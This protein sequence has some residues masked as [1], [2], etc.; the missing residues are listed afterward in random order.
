[1]K[2]QGGYTNQEDMRKAE[3][4]TE[5]SRRKHRKVEENKENMGEKCMKSIL[6]GQ[7]GACH[8]QEG[9]HL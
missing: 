2:E 6:L 3:E 9:V 1:M 7:R 8:S 4:S 5:N